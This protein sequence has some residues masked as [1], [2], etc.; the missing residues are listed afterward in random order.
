MNA[1]NAKI[2][3]RLVY[4]DLS[5]RAPRRYRVGKG[6]Q[7]TLFEGDPRKLYQDSKK[8]MRRVKREGA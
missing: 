3:R 4:R 6:G 7:R 8:E 1:R 5:Q 2:L